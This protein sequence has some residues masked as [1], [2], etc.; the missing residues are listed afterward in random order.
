[1]PREKKKSRIQS[2]L[3]RPSIFQALADQFADMAVGNGHYRQPNLR[4]V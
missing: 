4:L 1:M 2:T 3:D